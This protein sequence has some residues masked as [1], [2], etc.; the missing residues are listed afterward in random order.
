MS[1]IPKPSVRLEWCVAQTFF[2]CRVCGVGVLVNLAGPVPVLRVRGR[3]RRV[4]PRCV[5]TWGP[6]LLQENAE[7][8]AAESCDLDELVRM[9]DLA[10]PT[11]ADVKEMKAT[12][13]H[14]CSGTD[15]LVFFLAL[16]FPDDTYLCW[17]C[18]TKITTP[19]A[20]SMGDVQ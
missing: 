11:E 4:C 1:A 20:E 2:S 10:L 13:C 7:R 6:E 9:K 18:A 14:L 5:E 19:P 12:R 16:D 17:D 15:H 8:L 3:D